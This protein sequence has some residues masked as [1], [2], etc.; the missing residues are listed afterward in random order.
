MALSGVS[1]RPLQNLYVEVCSTPE[2]GVDI[3]EAL[4]NI[5][6]DAPFTVANW[7]I[8][9]TVS[10]SSGELYETGLDG[11]GQLTE[12]DV[13]SMLVKAKLSVDENSDEYKSCMEELLPL[14]MEIAHGISVGDDGAENAN[15]GAQAADKGGNL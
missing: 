12:K 13:F 6:K 3:H 10:L 7:K 15:N 5:L 8:Q 9:R 11:A 4:E 1:E 2:P 14:F